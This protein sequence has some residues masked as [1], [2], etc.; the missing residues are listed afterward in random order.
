MNI[1][2]PVKNKTASIG[3]CSKA[4]FIPLLLRFLKKE[5]MYLPVRI[6]CIFSK[7]LVYSL[8]YHRHEIP[9]ITAKAIEANTA[10]SSI[11]GYLRT[12]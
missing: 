7:I 3:C 2:T 12:F 4:D 1:V 9:M 11:L 6:F 5:G 10:R 8:K